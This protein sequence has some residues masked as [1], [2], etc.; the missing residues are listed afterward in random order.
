[1][2]VRCCWAAILISKDSTTFRTIKSVIQ[3]V[4]VPALLPYGRERRLASDHTF[5]SPP[6]FLRGLNGSRTPRDRVMGEQIAPAIDRQGLANGV[7]ASL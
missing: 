5:A 1:M 2:G 4:L 7:I 3:K 6:P